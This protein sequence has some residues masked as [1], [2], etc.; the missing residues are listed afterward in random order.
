MVLNSRFTCRL[1]PSFIISI[2]S[3]TLGGGPVLCISEAGV[4]GHRRRNA[5]SRLR[6][7]QRLHL[8]VWPNRSRK[9]LHHDGQTGTRAA[10]HHPTGERDQ[11]RHLGLGLNYIRLYT[12]GVGYLL[13]ILLDYLHTCLLSCRPAHL[14]VYFLA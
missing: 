3:L 10:G 14:L 9:V 8:C 1:I 6:R 2:V 11:T 13:T 12:C 7:L 4:F 5:A